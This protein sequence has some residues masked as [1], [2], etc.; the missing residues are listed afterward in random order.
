RLL[1]SGAIAQVVDPRE[2]LAGGCRASGVPVEG[3][4]KMGDRDAGVEMLFE[5]RS[6]LVTPGKRHGATSLSRASCAHRASTAVASRAPVT[7]GTGGQVDAP[8]YPWR[9]LPCCAPVLPLLPWPSTALAQER[10]ARR[11]GEPVDTG[12]R[13]EEEDAPILTPGQ[14][15]GQL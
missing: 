9:R 3:L 12:A 7:M 4:L 5:Q 2:A 15:R 10:A 11:G 6:R 1:R 14:V 13:R 8:R